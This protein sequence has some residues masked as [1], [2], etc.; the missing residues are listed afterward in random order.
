MT[1]KTLAEDRTNKTAFVVQVIGEKPKHRPYLRV[2][3]LDDQM[4]CTITN[5]NALRGLA[6]RILRALG[7]DVWRLV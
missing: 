7:D 4:V 1:T 6:R 3:D 5:A 2:A